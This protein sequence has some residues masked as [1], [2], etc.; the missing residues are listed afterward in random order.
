M[1]RGAL[2]LPPHRSRLLFRTSFLSIGS[3][4]AALYNRRFDSAALATLVFVTSVRFALPVLCVCVC[5]CACR[6]TTCACTRD[7]ARDRARPAPVRVP[8][9]C[10]CRQVNYW[11]RP[12]RD[13][14]RR[15]DICAALGS[16]GYQVLIA[17]PQA[18]L[19]ACLAYWLTVLLG[20]VFYAKARELGRLRDMTASS[21]WHA[22]L[23]VAGNVGN[24]LLYDALGKN[25]IGWRR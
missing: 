12:R 24:V 4:A 10:A 21:R 20:G 11:R 9:L 13:W 18:P 7:R 23:H 8:W 5:L 2:V 17:S 3:V 6:C 15:I 25:L 19:P 22:C 1:C 16:L 14:R